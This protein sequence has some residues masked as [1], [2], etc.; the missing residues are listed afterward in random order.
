MCKIKDVIAHTTSPFN[1]PQT[2]YYVIFEEEERLYEEIKP[3]FFQCE[4]NGAFSAL[5]YRR[6]SRD[7]FA[8][9]EFTIKLKDGTERVCKGDHWDVPPIS[10][11][12]IM[13]IGWG[14][15]EKLRKCYVFIGGCIRVS[16]LEEWLKNNDPKLEY[17][18]YRGY[19]ET[20][21]GLKKVDEWKDQQNHFFFALHG[22]MPFDKIHSLMTI[23]RE[24]ESAKKNLEYA[25]SNYRSKDKE[26]TQL[27]AHLCKEEG[28]ESEDDI[29][30]FLD[31][32]AKDANLDYDYDVADIQEILC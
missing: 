3:N 9:R 15:I 1:R 32:Y 2:R 24:L 25:R 8:G 10:Y 6:G 19:P 11:D 16:V 31:N 29:I 22:K 28:V 23:E 21:E 12:P 4:A 18:F 27:L 7:A 17:N 14:T 20:L 26:L 30:D 13:S 5:E